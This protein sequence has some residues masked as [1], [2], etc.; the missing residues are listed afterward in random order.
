MKPGYKTTEFWLAL[1]AQLVGALMVMFDDGAAGKALGAVAAALS[2][3]GY[4]YSRGK[5]K[6]ESNG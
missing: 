6:S 3:M 4:S 2:S 5:A 1:A